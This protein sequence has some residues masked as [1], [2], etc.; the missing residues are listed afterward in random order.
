MLDLDSSL[1]LAIVQDI[2]RIARDKYIF[3]GAGMR[4]NCRL[5]SNN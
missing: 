2:A 4:S 5:R 1:R 3:P